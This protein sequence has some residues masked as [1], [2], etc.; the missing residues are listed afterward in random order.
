MSRGFGAATFVEQRTALFADLA[1]RFGFAE[2]VG[3]ALGDPA[4]DAEAFGELPGVKRLRQ[5]WR[6]QAAQIGRGAE[7]VDAVDFD[8]VLIV[9]EMIILTPSSASTVARVAP[10]FD[11]D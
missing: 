6:Q 4:F 9:Y 2:A 8:E 3:H 5:R 7:L 11:F 1:D 10:F